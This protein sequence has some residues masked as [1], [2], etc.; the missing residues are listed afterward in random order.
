MR[1]ILTYHS[2]DRSGSPIS[3]PPEAFDR[4]VRWLATSGVRVVPLAELPATEGDAVALTFD[5]GFT[6]VAQE[7]APRLADHGLPATVF[8]VSGHAGGTNAWDRPVAGA[9]PAVPEMPLLDW[10]QL[11]RLG[12]RGL[13]VAAHTRSHP[14]LSGLSAAAATDEILGGA[15]E[16]ERRLGIRPST[17]AYPYGDVSATAADVA[18]ARFTCAVTTD[19]RALRPAEDPA[20]LPRLDAWYFRNPARLEAWGSAGFHAHVRAR[21]LA[22]RAR[23]W[24]RR[25]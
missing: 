7:A 20:R 6:S 22:R 4:H 5:D 2:I 24:L 21:A 19:M 8:V 9:R 25:A 10:E 23:G 17:F 14:R 13:T 1:V 12:D 15:D 18:R 11:G 16:I 3:V